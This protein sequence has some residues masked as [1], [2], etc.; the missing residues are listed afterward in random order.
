[1]TLLLAGCRAILVVKLATDNET[2]LAVAKKFNPFFKKINY[3][4]ELSR[5]TSANI[6]KVYT[7]EVDKAFNFC[8]LIEAAL[9]YR[10]GEQVI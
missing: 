2:S 5:T 4:R 8:L 3:S 9:E 10:V 7:A 6:S 1:M